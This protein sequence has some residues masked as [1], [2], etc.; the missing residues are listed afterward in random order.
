[1]RGLLCLVVLFAAS[2]SQSTIVQTHCGPVQG[3]YDQKLSSV[4]FLGIPYAKSTKE[5]KRWSKPEQLSQSDGSCWN[6]TLQATQ[7]GPMCPQINIIGYPIGEE[8]CLSI[9]VWTTNVAQQNEDNVK[10][11]PVMVF[12]H[13][14]SLVS[15][16]SFTPLYLA[17]KMVRG[18][19]VVSVSIQYRLGP[20][21]FLATESLSYRTGNSSNPSG[22]YGIMDQVLALHWVQH[23]I[24]AFGGD[25]DSITV[26]GQSSGGTSIFMLLASPLFLSVNPF[27]G[28]TKPLFHKAISMSGSVVIN[29]PLKRAQRDNA[30]IIQR[31]S[32]KG[33]TLEKELECLYK[34]PA[35]EI[36]VA[37][38][39]NTNLYPYWNNGEHI[40][41]LPFPGDYQPGIGIVDGFVLKESVLN[42]LGRTDLPSAMVPVV[43]GT[44]AQEVEIF[45]TYD[46]LQLAL[47]NDTQYSQYLLTWPKFND[48]IVKRLLELYPFAEYHHKSDLNLLTMTSDAR[49]VCGNI[50]LSDALYH[51][52]SSRAIYFYNSPQKFSFPVLIT[53]LRLRYAFHLLDN[54]LLMDLYDI[55]PTE[56]TPD[57]VYCSKIFF[58]SFTYFAENGAMPKDNFWTLFNNGTGSYFAN[59]VVGFSSKV[60][61]NFKKGQ[62]A[63]F[64]DLGWDD[65]WW[66]GQ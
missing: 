61:R 34:I 16:S 10:L 19:K 2:Y 21:G 30:V 55:L 31:T 52:N 24:R 62:C 60:E 3:I 15:E 22:N 58:D 12:I 20:L 28:D 37:A 1:M 63:F 47:L 54:I 7:F 25:P 56:I 13:G 41:V 66:T 42:A 45:T 64:H 17:H 46:L 18:K 39:G 29:T 5:H 57:I 65:H 9:N 38:L 27:T 33:M 53:P 6:G 8:D 49:A 4:A 14:G 32:C 23:N 50:A 26:Y 36:V 35:S 11:L 51:G 44:M 40:S 48:S 43:V 59:I